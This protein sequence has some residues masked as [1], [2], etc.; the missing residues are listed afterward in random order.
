MLCDTRDSVCDFRQSRLNSIFPLGLYRSDCLVSN[1]APS[2][3]C[4][5][6]VRVVLHSRMLPSNLHASWRPP[7]ATG[8]LPFVFQLDSI[9]GTHRGG[10]DKQIEPTLSICSRTSPLVEAESTSRTL[11]HAQLCGSLP[12]W[13]FAGLAAYQRA[14]WVSRLRAYRPHLRAFC[15]F[16]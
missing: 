16:T 11:I 5:T 8:W 2:Y 6:S 14:S 9:S 4:S 3:R 1:H 13:L 7:P 10:G 12:P 15:L